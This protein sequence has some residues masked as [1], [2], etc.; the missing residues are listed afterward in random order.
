MV[1]L[2]IVFVFKLENTLVPLTERLKV[3]FWVRVLSPPDS[4]FNWEVE[5][6]LSSLGFK[7]GSVWGLKP[8]IVLTGLCSY[9]FVF[10]QCIFCLYERGECG[11]SGTLCYVVNVFHCTSPVVGGQPVCSPVWDREPVHRPATSHPPRSEK[12]IQA[13][14]ASNVRA[15]AAPKTVQE[16]PDSRRSWASSSCVAHQV[17]KPQH[18]CQN[19]LRTTPVTTGKLGEFIAKKR[20]SA[21]H[22]RRHFEN[23]S[24]QTLCDISHRFTPA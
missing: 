1:V 8:I 4:T 22:D 17:S 13:R 12:W 15:E 10:S 3:G 6:P 5:G 19:T 18:W 11:D 14:R 2:Y 21:R 20:N 23:L 7:T 16:R 9:I 24:C